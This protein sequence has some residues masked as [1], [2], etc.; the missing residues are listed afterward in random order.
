MDKSRPSRTIFWGCAAAVFAADQVSKWLAFGSPSNSREYTI[1]PGVFFRLENP[2][3]VGIAWGLLQNWPQVVL[4]A[5]AVAAVVV[6]YYYYK[7]SVTSRV[8][9]ASLGL[10][11]GG[12]AGNLVDRAFVGHVRDFLAF[13]IGGF[14]WP[15]FNIADTFISGG[16]LLMI[17]VF[18]MAGK[19]TG[20]SERKSGGKAEKSDK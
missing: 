11:F 4:A 10:I 12:A 9:V 1:L 15:T 16:A 5:G 17:G 20:P 14:H 19:T 8:E 3:N 6:L 18:L 2:G 13:R 7:C